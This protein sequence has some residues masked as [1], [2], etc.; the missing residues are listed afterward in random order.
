M[1]ILKSFYIFWLHLCVHG[2]GAY[3]VISYRSDTQWTQCGY[4]SLD[5]LSNIWTIALQQCHFSLAT[6]CNYNILTIMCMGFT[7]WQYSLQWVMK[8]NWHRQ[9]A[10]LFKASFTQL[11]ISSPFLTIFITVTRMV[12]FSLYMDDS[13][14]NDCFTSTRGCTHE[15]MYTCTDI[16]S[17]SHRHKHTDTHACTPTHPHT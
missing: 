16:M 1:M 3:P 11:A 8:E 13:Q 9:N 5:G 15:H 10:Q 6:H 2:G 4:R 17:D 12:H 7:R 14:P